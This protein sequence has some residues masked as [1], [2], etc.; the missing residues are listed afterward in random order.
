MGLCTFCLLISAQDLR[1]SFDK[2][3]HSVSYSAV[4]DQGLV[5]ISGFRGEFWRVI[6]ADVNNL[7]L[8]WKVWAAFVGLVANGHNVVKNYPLELIYVLRMDKKINCAGFILI[9]CWV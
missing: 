1:Q 9:H 4:V 5:L 3:F 6:E 7:R 8:T 2:V